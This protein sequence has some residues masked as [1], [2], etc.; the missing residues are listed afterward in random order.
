MSRMQNKPPPRAGVRCFPSWLRGS[1]FAALGFAIAGQLASAA[2]L[3]LGC[4]TTTENSGLIAHLLPRFTAQSGV[5]VR[6]IARPTSAALRL[7]EHGDVDVL[8]VHHPALERA[9]IAAGHGVDRREVMRN[10]YVLLGP[11]ADAAHLSTGDP[12]HGASLAQPLENEEHAQRRGESDAI[13]HALTAIHRHGARFISRG[14]GSGTHLTEQALWRAASL[15]PQGLSWYRE[16]G[17]GM[18]V[19]LHVAIEQEAYLLSDRANWLRFGRSSQL[20]VFV[21]GDER[22]RNVYSVIRVNPTRHKHLRY[23]EARLFADWLTSDVGQRAIASFR[24]Q[25]EQ[26]FQP[27]AQ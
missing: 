16:V 24:P 15:V 9:F 7:G 18:G 22:L 17:A 26:L 6:A 19:A 8:F 12:A 3:T 10:D 20:R 5:P 25:G 23:Q 4:T 14:D 13:V 21:A 11:L 27:V 1:G 2:P